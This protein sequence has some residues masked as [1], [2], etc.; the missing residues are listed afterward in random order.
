MIKSYEEFN[1]IT[2]DL[3]IPTLLDHL[4]QLRLFQRVKQ[5]F[6]NEVKILETEMK[7]LVQQNKTML[8]ITKKAVKH[9]IEYELKYSTSDWRAIYGKN[10]DS[11]LV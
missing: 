11:E 5:M 2:G 9:L 4:T 3:E 10:L 1:T 6:T 7:E 8:N